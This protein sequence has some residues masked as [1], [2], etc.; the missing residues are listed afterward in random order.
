MMLVDNPH[1]AGLDVDVLY[2]LALDTSM[3]LVAMFGDVK[4]VVLGGSGERMRKVA[5]AA[6]D[7]F[8]ITEELK[9]LCATDRYSLY[10]VG[11]IISVSHGMGMPSI[12]ILLHEL[13]KLMHYA[14]A[15]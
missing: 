1:L 9:N 8:G 2:H 12:G 15:D 5:E 7:R 4:F 6:A 10:K 13:A 3:D 14:K 11:P